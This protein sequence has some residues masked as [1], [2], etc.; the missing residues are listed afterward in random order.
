MRSRRRNHSPGF[1]AKAALAALK[2]DK[3]VAELSQQFEVHPNQISTWKKQLMENAEGV[4]GDGSGKKAVGEK[5]IKKLHSKIGHGD[6]VQVNG[7]WGQ[8][9]GGSDYCRQTLSFSPRDSLIAPQRSSLRH[10]LPSC[11]RTIPVTSQFL[12]RFEGDS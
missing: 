5:Q 3:T 2:G 8:Y 1:K 6:S 10:S 12:C 7:F 11:G 9:L 4:F